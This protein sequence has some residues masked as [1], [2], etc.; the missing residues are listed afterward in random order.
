[1]LSWGPASRNGTKSCTG[2]R[3]RIVRRRVSVNGRV[4]HFRG[5]D[6]NEEGNKSSGIFFLQTGAWIVAFLYLSSQ[7]EISIQYHP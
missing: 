6:G 4:L 7:I 5:A 1:M 3:W 2:E